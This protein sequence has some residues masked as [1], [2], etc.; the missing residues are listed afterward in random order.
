M[1]CLYVGTQECFVCNHHLKGDESAPEK[2][3]KCLVKDCGRFYHLSCLSSYQY[4]KIEGGSVVMC[5]L[6]VCETCASEE[7]NLKDPKSLKGE[8]PTSQFVLVICRLR[9]NICD[10]HT[11]TLCCLLCLQDACS[12]A[13]VVRR[14]TTW[15]TCA[16]RPAPNT[17]PTVSSPAANTT[18]TGKSATS[19]FHGA[20]PVHEVKAVQLFELKRG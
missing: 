9:F 11:L 13:I 4:A 1:S 10:V 19:T 2:P 12:A 6:H 7:K 15:A 8:H 5:P 20:S 14:R 16:S 17:S 3:L 18:Q